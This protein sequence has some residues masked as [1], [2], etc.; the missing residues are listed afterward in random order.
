METDRT[1]LVETDRT[2]SPPSAVDLLAARPDPA[3]GDRPHRVDLPDHAAEADAS[4]P[5]GWESRTTIRLVSLAALALLVV[6]VVVGFDSHS[7][8]G[9]TSSTLVAT[10]AELRHTLASVATARAELTAVTGQADVAEHTLAG[11][12]AELAADQARLARSQADEFYQGVSINQ[13]DLC[14]AGVEK[15]LNQISLGDPSGAAT[16]LNGVAANCQGAEPGG[17]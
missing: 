6:A 2:A 17:T 1:P 9:R 16:T 5:T 11:A 7:Q 4:R 12:E 14:L 8:L 3:V 13:L 15:S 10:R